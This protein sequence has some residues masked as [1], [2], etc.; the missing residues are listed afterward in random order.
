M[1]G[2]ELTPFQKGQIDGAHKFGHT[3]TEIQKV[4][5]FAR[6]TIIDLIK[7][8]KIRGSDENKERVGR[9]RKSFDRDDR[10]LLRKALDDTKIPLRELKFEANSDLSISTIRRRL[11]EEDVQKWL[12]AERPRLTET[13]ASKRYDFAKKYKDLTVD[14]WRKY[15]FSDE[16]SVEKGADPRQMWVFRRPSDSE[17]FK[18]K[19]VKPKDKCKGVSVMVWAC[20]A[21]DQRGPLVTCHGHMRAVQYV[22]ILDENL[23]SFIET[24]PEDIKNDVIFQ[25]DNATIHTARVTKGWFEDNEIE[26]LDWPPNSPD[27]N[28][29]EHVWKELKAKLHYQ[30]PDTYALRGG[31]ERVQEVLAERLQVV[32]NELDAHVFD[33]LI[34]SMPARI[35]ALYDAKGW[36]TRY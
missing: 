14:D 36:Y 22:N 24:L 13:H 19:N 2:P 34:L 10:I 27:M 32:W 25:Q 1:R 35:Q 26:L 17:K 11:K 5:G 3:P 8:I 31:P 20:F 29:I 12:A 15:I 30:F 9:P 7:R 33:R 4:L 28:P 23:P 16:C 18:P 6:G 21:S